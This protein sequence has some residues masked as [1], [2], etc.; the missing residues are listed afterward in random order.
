MQNGFIAM[1]LTS[2]DQTLLVWQKIVDGQAVAYVDK[3][4]AGIDLPEVYE[5]TVVSTDLLETLA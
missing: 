2:A 4:G 3:A 1:S 5:M